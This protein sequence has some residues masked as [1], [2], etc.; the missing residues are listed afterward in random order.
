[1]S[2]PLRPCA[3]CGA[4]LPSDTSG[5]L[6]PRCLLLR[7]AEPTEPGS[8]SPETTTHQPP[9]SLDAVAAAFPQLEILSLI[10]QGG[11]GVVYRAR[12]K[13]LGRMVA[14]KLLAP[15]RAHDTA[16]ADRFAQE[17]RALAA[18]S[19]PHIVTI[20]DFGRSADFYFL[21]MEFVDGVNLRH[22]LQSRR[23]SPEEAIAI[24]PSLCEALQFAHE[25]GI[26]HRDI[27]PENLLLD[28]AGRVKI[29]DFGIAKI[30]GPEPGPGPGPSES[31]SA[32]KGT[33]TVGTP[34]YMAPEQC[35]DPK[36]AD[37]R[38][39]IYSLG[40]VFY[41]MLTGERPDERLQPP[42]RRV[43][44]DV[45]LDAIVLRAL[46]AN[47]ERRYQ[48]ADELR[49]HLETVVVEPSPSPAP[50]LSA[51]EVPAGQKTA[52]P[53][54][55]PQPPHRPE[56]GNPARLFLFLL[57]AVTLVILGP[58]FL[59]PAPS[60]ARAP[61]IIGALVGLAGGL[62]ALA[63]WH[64]VFRR[65]L[66]HG[67]RPSAA[68]LVAGLFLA[69]TAVSVGGIGTTIH[70]AKRDRWRMEQT[71]RVA[72]LQ[73]AL[74][75][76]TS[77]E[78]QARAALAE[79]EVP[80]D[81]NLS[82][83]ANR[84]AADNDRLAGSVREAV[85]SARSAERELNA[86]TARLAAL[87]SSS[88]PGWVL[89]WVPALPL[90]LAAIVVPFRRSLRITG[91][92]T[93]P[94]RARL[95]G[96]IAIVVGASAAA[97]GLGGFFGKQYDSDPG[98]FEALF[99]P[100][101]MPPMKR[102]GWTAA[103]VSNN[104]VLADLVTELDAGTAEV[105]WEFSGPHLPEAVD[106]ALTD[107]LVAKPPGIVLRPNPYRGNTTR[108]L[109]REGRHTT[110]VAFVLPDAALAAEALRAF[111]GREE[112]P[113][114]AGESQAA[115]L[116]HILRPAGREFRAGFQIGKPLHSGNPE[117]VACSRTGSWNE[118][119]LVF[120]WTLEAARPGTATVEWGDDRSTAST[121]LRRRDGLISVRIRIQLT[122][123]GTNAVRIARSVGG[124]SS[125][126]DRPGSYPSLAAEV[127][128]TASSSTRCF[129]GTSTELCRIDGQSLVAR[130]EDSPPEF[131]ILGNPLPVSTTG[132]SPRLL[133][134]AFF[135]LASLGG[136]GLLVIARIWRARSKRAGHRAT[137]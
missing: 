51:P 58:M 114:A 127:L 64:L 45:R 40:V 87:R 93:R 108:I 2:D 88:A 26:V 32:P 84:L 135:V 39:D 75:S 76:A 136:L 13:S 19:H 8:T 134:A 97:L 60:T 10:G 16:F 121:S 107:P 25:R 47:P 82:N 90:F 21:L 23:L 31:A 95:V 115:T 50:A 120:T 96:D 66:R 83:P 71:E 106:T 110:R 20:H 42:S 86:A 63:A 65:G 126:T 3:Q 130:F 56:G 61:R 79:R 70:N 35:L 57:F 116:F 128:R 78:V 69:L 27:K 77:N 112:G 22:L 29:A 5:G 33:Q 101:P 124:A 113:P 52:S 91:G 4:Q 73:Q 131:P 44:I 53:P 92:A 94:E 123:I 133:V 12:Q 38:A 67:E 54:P 125:F 34:G 102:L 81:E 98:A 89:G 99:A 14:L 119:G 80:S 55:I 43:R 74:G 59:V 111:S 41:E 122:P 1:M 85:E 103:G 62:G 18:L 109:L 137:P 129:R 11:M 17:A 117:W 132:I 6:C 72:T 49:T 104:V 9:P 48:T 15:H 118:N 30:L 7:V 28:Q 24:V 68:R 105:V 100:P 37:S 36:T 46:D